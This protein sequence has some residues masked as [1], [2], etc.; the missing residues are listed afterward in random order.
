LEKTRRDPAQGPPDLT[1][2]LTARERKRFNHLARDR[3]NEAMK[4]FAG[5][6]ASA[7]VILAAWGAN[8]QML[9]P[10][11]AG[12][13][14]YQSASDF[15]APY[16]EPPLTFSPRPYAPS[17]GY[18][19]DYNDGAGYGYGPPLMPPE[20]V[21]A[22]LRE[23]G[24]SPL[25]I[26]HQRGLV[27]EIA[28]MDRGGEDGRLIIDARNGRIIR[29]MPGFAWGRAYDRM[30]NL[31]D[32]SL[33]SAVPGSVPTMTAVRGVPRPPA[34]VPH[35]TSRTVPMPSPKPAIAGKPQEVTRQS[36]VIEAKPADSAPPAL[37]PGATV[38]EA[39]PAP[40][41][42]P[43]QAMPAVQALE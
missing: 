15:D 23:N 5:W 17:Y 32:A 19:R 35:V 40:P 26:P 2:T 24:F 13:A 28:V 25:G 1:P 29:F 38:G 42:L 31:P 6:I 30:G 39:R 8:A 9:A 4:L 11:D 34:P 16:V 18:G 22:V 12:R 41:I 33:P 27:Y 21:Y 43:T 7:S 10:Y 36:A 37:Q 14:R 3:S 20:E